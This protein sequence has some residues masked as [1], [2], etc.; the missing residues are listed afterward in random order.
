MKYN[1]FTI[2]YNVMVLLPLLFTHPPP[3]PPKKTS[4]STLGR[5]PAGA[6][7]DNSMSPI[8]NNVWK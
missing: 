7:A 3:P 6:P 8:Y 4:V 2:T 1:H 5:N